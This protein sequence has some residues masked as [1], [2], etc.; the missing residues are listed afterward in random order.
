M[1]DIT[2]D[3]CC[4]IS[5]IF[6][7]GVSSNNSL[8]CLSIPEIT[9]FTHCCCVLVDSE[10]MPFVKHFAGMLKTHC[11]VLPTAAV[12]ILWSL[13]VCFSADLV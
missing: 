5:V 8:P 7:S 13:L 11:K 12:M 10:L 3:F 6:G 9:P 4:Y 1:A 2:Y